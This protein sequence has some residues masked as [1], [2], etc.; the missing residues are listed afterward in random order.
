VSSLLVAGS[1]VTLTYDDSANT[2]TVASSGGGSGWTDVILGSD[3]STTSAVFDASLEWA[4]VPLDGSSTYEVEA[5]MIWT[6]AATTTGLAHMV[7][8]AMAGSHVYLNTVQLTTTTI[9]NGFSTNGASSVTGTTSIASV[10]YGKVEGMS[11]TGV[12][13]G[14]LSFRIRSEVSGSLVTIKAGSFVR[15]RKVQ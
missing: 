2:L 9:A 8:T 1:N 5:R 14:T 7:Y 3:F 4:S 6:A 13:S 11:I 10:N 12:S 15:Y